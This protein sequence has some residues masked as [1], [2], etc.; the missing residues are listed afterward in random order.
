MGRVADFPSS[1]AGFSGNEGS[2]AT[3]LTFQRNGEGLPR[4]KR[5]SHLTARSRCSQ[6]GVVVDAPLGL[7]TQRLGDGNLPS[8][9]GSPNPADS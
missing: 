1:F 9:R 3:H 4:L 6:R 2:E 5:L 7:G 8:G